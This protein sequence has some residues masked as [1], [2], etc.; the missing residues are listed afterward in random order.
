MAHCRTTT[1]QFILQI[2]LVPSGERRISRLLSWHVDWFE[3]AG[4]GMTKKDQVY[5]SPFYIFHLLHDIQLSH[6][7]SML[8][9]AHH[10]ARR[11]GQIY[12]NSQQNHYQNRCLQSTHRMEDTVPKT[13]LVWRNREKLFESSR[14]ELR[15][16]VQSWKSH[17]KR[18]S[19]TKWIISCWNE[20][21][22]WIGY[23]PWFPW[24][25]AMVAVEINYGF[26]GKQPWLPYKLTVQC[27]KRVLKLSEKSYNRK[28]VHIVSVHSETNLNKS[29][30]HQLE[31]QRLEI[32]RKIRDRILSIRWTAIKKRK[33][34]VQHNITHDLATDR[35][36]WR[37]RNHTT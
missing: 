31:N 28:V 16:E 7:L 26:H 3:H 15:Y 18:W 25:R 6:H 22:Q 32:S 11:K 17:R 2:G 19:R 14:F 30:V 21:Y 24:T 9:S 5:I 27:S 8:R 29:N 10:M 33:I 4:R 34:H 12:K 36:S 1:F 37:M 20:V 23:F 13:S 35:F